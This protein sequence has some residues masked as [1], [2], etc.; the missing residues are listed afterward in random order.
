M[1]SGRRRTGA[2]A[3]PRGDIMASHVIPPR[4]YLLVFLALVVLTVITVGLDLLVRYNLMSIG[5]AQ[6]PLALL[7]AVVKA[8][9][10]ILFFMHVWNSPKL[11]WV[12]ALG[13]LL[14]LAILMGYT[15]TDYLSRTW[16]HVPGS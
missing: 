4:T 11:T 16:V 13:S 12:V 7:I 8:T 14:W 6:H 5:P 1:G 10:V 3:L 2:P 15:L 9:L